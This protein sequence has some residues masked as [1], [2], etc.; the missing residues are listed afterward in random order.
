MG[1]I[2]CPESNPYE[3]KD[4][5][6]EKIKNIKPELW[7][8]G[9]KVTQIDDGIYQLWLGAENSYSSA[10]YMKNGEEPKLSLK[11]KRMDYAMHSRE[12]VLKHPKFKEIFGEFSDALKIE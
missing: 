6:I 3:M 7:N 9:W 10:Y 1:V 4:E 12:A 5:I 8:P 11:E 2:K